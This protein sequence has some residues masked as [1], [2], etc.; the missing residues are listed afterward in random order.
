M[1]LAILIW[2]GG[3]GRKIFGHRGKVAHAFKC[4]FG[5]ES[6]KSEELDKSVIGVLFI[7][8]SYV[9]FSQIKEIC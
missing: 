4:G 8:G 6:Q 5:K 9:V 2:E 1:S 3:G 7:Q